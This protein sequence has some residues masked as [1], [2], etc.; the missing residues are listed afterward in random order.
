M[1]LE[2][3]SWYVRFTAL[4]DTVVS[5]DARL[6]VLFHVLLSPQP[7]PDACLSEQRVMEICGWKVMPNARSSTNVF[8]ALQLH[9]VSMKVTCGPKNE[10]S[11]W[12]VICNNEFGDFC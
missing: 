3:N 2:L 6:W 7:W 10:A 9:L 8:R 12:K 1:L 5:R 4:S 11:W